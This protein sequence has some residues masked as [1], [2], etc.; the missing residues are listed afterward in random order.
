MY[1]PE[2]VRERSRADGQDAS[3]PVTQQRHRRQGQPS[4]R[5]RRGGGRCQKPSPFLI[6]TATA[7]VIAPLLDRVVD[8]TSLALPPSTHLSGDG[9]ICYRGV[10]VVIAVAVDGGRRGAGGGSRSLE[11]RGDADIGVEGL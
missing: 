8:C 1:I 2:D 6:S 11:A 3:V 5:R 7:H 9:T 4:R 10:A